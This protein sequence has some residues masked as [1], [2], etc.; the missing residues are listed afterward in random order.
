MDIGI[1]K[2]EPDDAKDD[3]VT[4]SFVYPLRTEETDFE[5][6][7]AYAIRMAE[8]CVIQEIHRIVVHALEQ[9]HTLMCISRQ[10]RTGSSVADFRHAIETNHKKFHSLPLPKKLMSFSVGSIFMPYLTFVESITKARNAMEHRRGCVGTQDC[11]MGDKL[12][13]SLKVPHALQ[14]I[15]RSSPQSNEVL[16]AQSK[17]VDDVIEFRKGQTVTFDA[18][19]IMGIMLTANFALKGII[20]WIYELNGFA[21]SHD[22]ILKQFF[23]Q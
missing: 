10:K 2:V 18:L 20:D 14:V 9:A 12:R 22:Q 4:V 8:V 11:N 23:A 19:A 7:R 17:F 1:R 6:I 15:R 5:G 21:D 13:V 3:L 16:S